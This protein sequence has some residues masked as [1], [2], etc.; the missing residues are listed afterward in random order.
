MRQS[1]AQNIGQATDMQVQQ[2][3][4]SEHIIV[5]VPAG[6]QVQVTFISPTRAAVSN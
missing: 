2:M 3:Q 4:V 5:T 6:T 1:A